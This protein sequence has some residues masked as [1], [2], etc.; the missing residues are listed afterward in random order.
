MANVLATETKA[1]P[2]AD[3]SQIPMPE[4]GART[5]SDDLLQ[6]IDETLDL[7]AEAQSI[8]NG[9]VPLNR[10]DISVVVPVYNA[11]ETLPEVLDRLEEVMPPATE[12][13]VVDDGSTDETWQVI[14]HRIEQHRKK[15]QQ[16]RDNESAE[17]SVRPRL[18]GLRRR[19][20]H[21]RGSAIRMAVRHARGVVIGIQ[22]AD[23]AYDPADL[24]GAI[25]PIL[26]DKADVV[27]GSRTMRHGYTS[28]DGW[29]GWWAKLGRRC[30]TAYSNRLTGLRLTDVTVGQKVFRA[31]LLRDLSLSE[32][33]LGFDAEVTAKVARRADTIMEIPTHYDGHEKL[34]F[35]SPPMETLRE[36]VRSAWQHRAG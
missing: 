26:E 4:S 23:L 34:A 13:I 17:T 24:L 14:R 11:A 12:T 9:A 28:Y 2:P 6:R 31:D 29:P 19:R 1:T 21:G 18:F 22:D 5:V 33:G 36:V 32:T 25:W 35:T 3:V 16:Q 8:A 10:V 27:Y 15:Q 7:I 30:L 20:H